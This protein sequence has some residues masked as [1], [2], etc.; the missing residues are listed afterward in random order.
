MFTTRLPS[1]LLLLC[2]CVICGFISTPADAATPAQKDPPTDVPSTK[3]SP[4]SMGGNFEGEA[5]IFLD[6]DP[7]HHED[8][9]DP[10]HGADLK[11]G[12]TT[13]PPTASSPGKV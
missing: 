13:P 1:S 5:D 3:D 2:L 9:S 12:E 11:V 10:D 4:L 8:A 7:S 6:T